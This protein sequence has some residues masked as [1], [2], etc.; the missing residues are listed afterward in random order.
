M[1]YRSETIQKIR[2][3]NFRHSFVAMLC[4]LGIVAVSL[5]SA[6]SVGE[7]GWD[8]TARA[9]EE[10]SEGLG[11]E[12]TKVDSSS[13]YSA[14]GSQPFYNCQGLDYLSDFVHFSVPDFA[15]AF[16]FLSHFEMDVI[17]G[18]HSATSPPARN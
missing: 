17:L 14:T 12:E 6:W 18:A 3:I 11:A 16:A 10:F 2:P 9:V 1:F 4:S 5:A 8:W 7:T 13:A 15:L